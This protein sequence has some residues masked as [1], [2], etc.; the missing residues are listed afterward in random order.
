MSTLGNGSE[1]RGKRGKEFT[2]GLH[3]WGRRGPPPPWLW[4]SWCG[5]HTLSGCLWEA[6][7]AWLPRFHPGVWVFSKQKASVLLIQQPKQTDVC[8]VTRDHLVVMSKWL[9]GQEKTVFLRGEQAGVPW[10]LSGAGRDCRRDS[11]SQGLHW[12]VLSAWWKGEFS[13]GSP[14]YLVLGWHFLLGD[15]GRGVFAHLLSTC[16]VPGLSW[17][18]SCYLSFTEKKIEA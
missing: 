8:Y 15:D 16:P 9:G 1:I 18:D 7:V 10:P 5:W 3:L 4:E 12:S 11:P 6:E 2:S 14:G 17:A 13:E